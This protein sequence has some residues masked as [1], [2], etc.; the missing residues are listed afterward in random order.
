MGTYDINQI[1]VWSLNLEQFVDKHDYEAVE[2]LARE[3]QKIG[4]RVLRKEVARQLQSK[5]EL[6]ASYLGEL[7]FWKTFD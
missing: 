2:Q 6:K 1:Q 7:G 4:G 5:N 3:L